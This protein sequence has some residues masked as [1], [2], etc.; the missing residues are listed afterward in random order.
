M[1]IKPGSMWPYIIAG[2]LALH[3]VGSMVMV[4]FATSND[5]YAV[6]PDYYAKALHWDDKRAQDRANTALG[7]QL[8]FTVE[9]A[10]AG[11]DPT[12]RVELTSADGEP[13]TDAVVA[14]EAFSNVR[15]DDVLSSILAATDSGYGSTLPMHGDGRWEFRFTVTRGDDL[16]TFRDTR[17]IWTQIID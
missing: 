2:A 4:Y 6:E 5:S 17:H 7:W 3:V 15:R 12:L 1:K 13:V 9:P 14:V 8:E 16:F 11:Q 10:A